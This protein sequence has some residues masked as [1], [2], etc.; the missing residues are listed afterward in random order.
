MDIDTQMT[1]LTAQNF[2]LHLQ[3]LITTLNKSDKCLIAYSGGVDS[4]VLL[5]LCATLK[6]NSTANTAEFSAV[7]I[8]HGLSQNAQQWGLHAQHICSDLDIPF[9]LIEVDGT[10]KKGQ[11]PEAAARIARYNALK[12]LVTTD[13]YLLT[14]QHQDD[15]AE[16]VLLQLLRGSGVKGLSAMPSI[17]SFAQGFLCRPL[18]TY[19]KQDILAYADTH[20]LSWIEDES[21]AQECFDRNYLRHS[22]FPLLEQHWSKVRENFAKSA[23][24]L[25]ESQSVLEKNATVE[26]QNLFPINQQG[27]IEY[28]KLDV[29]SALTLLNKEGSHPFASL[30]NVL[31]YWFTLNE[32]VLP[33]RK[34]LKQ[35]IHTVLLAKKEAMPLIQWHDDQ[36]YCTLRRYQ[37][38]LYL[39]HSSSFT[40]TKTNKHTIDQQHYA[41]VDYQAITLNHNSRIHCIHSQVEA[42]Q[43]SFESSVLWSQAVTIR[44]RQGGERFRKNKQGSSHKLKH[45]FQEQAI[46]PW[47]R[48]HIPLI[49]WGETLFQIGNTVVSDCLKEAQ[50]KNIVDDPVVILWQKSSKN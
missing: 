39:F 34:V 21:N 19:T 18:L 20:Q 30:N 26:C 47:E 16:T 38:I 22:I 31:R 28:H 45:W 9:T 14:A 7:Y 41:L 17:K 15:Q 12:P 44:F 1:T 23:G 43:K 2:L 32:C 10:A 42:Y 48:D 29:T 50:K 36:S 4:H 5:H 33:S 8:N 24:I 11:S 40:D 6:Q 37:N 13:T 27:D 46:P 25:A 3:Q 49:F 35:I